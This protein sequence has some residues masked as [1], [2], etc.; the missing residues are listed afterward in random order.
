MGGC[1]VQK[2]LARV[3]REDKDEPLKSSMASAWNMRVR[4]SFLQPLLLY[5][6]VLLFV[7]L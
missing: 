1:Y 5:Y 4:G 6:V 7:C 2:A 3:P